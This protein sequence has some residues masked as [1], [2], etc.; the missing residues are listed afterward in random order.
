MLEPS[1]SSQASPHWE[2]T[3]SPLCD[4]ARTR[5]LVTLRSRFQKTYFWTLFIVTM[6]LRLPTRIH[7]VYE[8]VLAVVLLVSLADPDGEH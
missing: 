1:H 6:V 5:H 8:I 7:S 3:I 4:A 2:L